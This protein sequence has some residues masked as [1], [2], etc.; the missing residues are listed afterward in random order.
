MFC[1]TFLSSAR[2]RM[3]QRHVVRHFFGMRFWL[4]QITQLAQHGSFYFRTARWKQM[5]TSNIG[6]RDEWQIRWRSRGWKGSATTLAPEQATG[7]SDWE[8]VPE[9]HQHA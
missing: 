3:C 7:E 4:R 8:I 5:M 9:L 6:G 2:I 1:G